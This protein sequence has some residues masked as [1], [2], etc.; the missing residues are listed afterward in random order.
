MNSGVLYIFSIQMQKHFEML[1]CDF[2]GSKV[3]GQDM[4]LT[5]LDSSAYRSFDLFVFF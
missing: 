5:G 2:T 3:T 4:A 1:I